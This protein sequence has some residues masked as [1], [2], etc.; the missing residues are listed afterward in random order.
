MSQEHAVGCGCQGG[1]TTQK[2]SWTVD[3]AGT[4]KTFPDGTTAKTYSL[5][6]EAN[7]AINS[8]GLTGRLRP[9]PAST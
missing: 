5:A 4:G 9:K 7:A 1:K 8:L 3:L 6:G 2:L